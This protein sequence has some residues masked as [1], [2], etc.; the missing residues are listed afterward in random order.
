MMKNRNKGGSTQAIN[1]THN[2][3]STVLPGEENRL[4]RSQPIAP[5]RASG[6][7]SRSAGVVR[8]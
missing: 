4:V 3:V 8:K 1:A 2:N 5:A 7:G 6:G